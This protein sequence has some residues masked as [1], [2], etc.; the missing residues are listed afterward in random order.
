MNELLAIVLE[1]ETTL[2]MGIAGWGTLL[3]SL[4]VTVAWVAYLYR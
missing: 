2:P 4:A 3:V 1:A